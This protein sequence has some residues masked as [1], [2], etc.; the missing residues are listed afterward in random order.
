MKTI[1]EKDKR[2]VHLDANKCTKEIMDALKNGIDKNKRSER[3]IKE[4]KST[5][6][7]LKTSYDELV[8]QDLLSVGGNS[9][10]N[11]RSTKESESSNGTGSGSVTECNLKLMNKQLNWS[12][13]RPRVNNF[14]TN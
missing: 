12:A 13:P 8:K 9:K 10:R 11:T 5:L 7:S 3:E 4:L 1:S 6:N 2:I 14:K